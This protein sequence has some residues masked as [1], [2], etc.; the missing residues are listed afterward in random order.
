MDYTYSSEQ[1]RRGDF[2]PSS[3]YPFR[4]N[5]S[6]QLLFPS[7]DT[8]RTL[9][10][11]RIVETEGGDIS[12]SMWVAPKSVA[13]PTNQHLFLDWSDTAGVEMQEI[14]AAK[15]SPFLL[16]PAGY[17]VWVHATTGTGNIFPV[18]YEV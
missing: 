17:N 3:P 13:T 4:T 11:Y 5:G 9:S 6:L 10:G 14:S 16:V 15:F 2:Y 18:M 7:K 1:L 8:D 12:V